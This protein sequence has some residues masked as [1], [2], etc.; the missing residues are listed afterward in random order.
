MDRTIQ[1]IFDWVTCNGTANREVAEEVLESLKDI[2]TL[3]SRELERTILWDSWE[4]PGW[5]DGEDARLSII[6]AVA[7]LLKDYEQQRY[8]AQF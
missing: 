6:E 1:I 7:S 8:A 3:E 4:M 2:S 5:F